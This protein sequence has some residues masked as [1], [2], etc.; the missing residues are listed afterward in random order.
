MLT[1]W[2]E[3]FTILYCFTTF[4]K[5]YSLR[6]VRINGSSSLPQKTQLLKCL[7]HLIRSLASNSVTWWHHTTSPCHLG[8]ITWVI[9]AW[10]I[11]IFKGKVFCTN[12]GWAKRVK[13]TCFWVAWREMCD[14]LT[15]K[16]KESDTAAPILTLPT[17]WMC[18]TWL[19]GHP[20]K[21]LLFFLYSLCIC[22]NKNRPVQ[23][24]LY[25]LHPLYCSN[26]TISFL[27]WRTSHHIN[28]Q[29]SWLKRMACTLICWGQQ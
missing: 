25:V 13:Q 23:S 8:D 14:F 27:Q 20:F 17:V 26:T 12:L 2:N 15:L 19:L 18:N 9:I 29:R 21:M 22:Y 16:C 28:D 7:K 6:N 11:H 10:M 1:H 5:I 4:R 24:L 3:S